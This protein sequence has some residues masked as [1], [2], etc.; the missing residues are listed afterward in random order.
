ML[1][2]LKI[3]LDLETCF[4]L[5]IPLSIFREEKDIV[6]KLFVEKKKILN[7]CTSFMFVT[8]FSS[9]CEKYHDWRATLS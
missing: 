2:F 7:L 1:L 6:I 3:S 8:V 4:L 9:L 5:K